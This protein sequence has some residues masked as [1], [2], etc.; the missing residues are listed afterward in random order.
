MSQGGTPLVENT[1]EQTPQWD[2]DR[3]AMEAM[4]GVLSPVEGF[5]GRARGSVLGFFSKVH[6]LGGAVLR[7]RHVRLLGAM[8][9]AALGVTARAANP[10][11]LCMLML[12]MTVHVDSFLAPSP[13]ALMV[14][15]G[16]PDLALQVA[17]ILS[18]VAAVFTRPVYWNAQIV[19]AACLAVVLP[20]PRTRIELPRGDVPRRRRGEVAADKEE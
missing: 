15:G 7:I 4:D 1:A 12:N 18:F 13:Q 6:A 16:G 10:V 3:E 5:V 19:T 17:N 14:R 11:T 2:F 8:V 9:A 20:G